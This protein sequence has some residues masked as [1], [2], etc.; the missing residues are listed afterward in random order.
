L[1]YRLAILVTLT[2]LLFSDALAQK[3]SETAKLKPVAVPTVAPRPEDV[4]TLDGIMKAFYETIS[5]TAGQPR[6]WGRDRTLG[7]A[8]KV[9]NGAR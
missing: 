1:Q 3:P 2:L 9:K 4:S 7:F 5:G 6:Q 8:Q